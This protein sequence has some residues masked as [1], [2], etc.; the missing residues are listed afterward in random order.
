VETNRK[1][2]MKDDNGTER[3]EEEMFLNGFMR[4]VLYVFL[5]IFVKLFIKKQ[6]QRM[7]NGKERRKRKGRISADDCIEWKQGN[8]TCEVGRTALR[9]SECSCGSSNVKQTR[10]KSSLTERPVIVT[11]G[12]GVE[13]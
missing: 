9:G 8:G 4:W 6:E 13:W 11:K 7:K 3:E 1:G 10:P 5:G 2:V 12:V